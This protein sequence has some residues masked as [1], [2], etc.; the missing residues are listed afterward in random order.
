MKLDF[1]FLFVNIWH[2]PNIVG[3]FQIFP[4]DIPNISI[5]YCQKYIKYTVLYILSF[6]STNV[7]EFTYHVYT[8]G[9]NL[10]FLFGPMQI[11]LLSAL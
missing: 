9:L 6:I 8:V 7:I 4:D 5:F 3:K 1:F 2:L 11:Y 10:T